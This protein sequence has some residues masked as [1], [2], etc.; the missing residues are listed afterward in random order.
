MSLAI[1]APANTSVVG[2]RYP[3]QGGYFIIAAIGLLVLCCLICL[4]QG[5]VKP[6]KEET[7]KLETA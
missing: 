7:L 5:V 4:S 3:S 1:Q 6:A 2:E